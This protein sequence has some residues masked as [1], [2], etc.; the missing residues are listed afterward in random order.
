[1]TANMIELPISIPIDGFKA[2][3]FMQKTKEEI[4][5]VIS[6]LSGIELELYIKNAIESKNLNP[7]EKSQVKTIK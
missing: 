4:N 5:S 1:M 2:V 3:E 6:D 7:K